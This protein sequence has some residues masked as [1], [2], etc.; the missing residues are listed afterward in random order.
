[1]SSSNG[2]QPSAVWYMRGSRPSDQPPVTHA[3]QP[4]GDGLFAALCDDQPVVPLQGR[5]D[6]AEAGACPLCAKLTS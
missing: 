6:P 3:M 5:F 1:M 4:R 2:S